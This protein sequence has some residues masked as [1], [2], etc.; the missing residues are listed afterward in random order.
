MSAKI[1]IYFRHNKIPNTKKE[2]KFGLGIN[3]PL[4][5]NMIRE[6]NEKSLTGA[7]T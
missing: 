1:H 2:A 7:W 6:L 3:K 4:R 5:A